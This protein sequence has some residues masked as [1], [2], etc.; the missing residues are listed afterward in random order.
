MKEHI[1]ASINISL[2]SSLSALNLFC[3]F[4]LYF[5]FFYVL[6]VSLE[7]SSAI[8]IVLSV[9]LSFLLSPLTFFVCPA[10]CLICMQPSSTA[11]GICQLSYDQVTAATAS[12]S[13][14]AS[15]SV[16]C[17]L[18]LPDTLRLISSFLSLF[19]VYCYQCIAHEI[20]ILLHCSVA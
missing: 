19:S 13:D 1:S 7:F 2:Q 10:L 14:S 3:F 18:F 16:L 9:L 17:V 15:L 12:A 11:P 6:L 4:S 5:L 8:I 20:T